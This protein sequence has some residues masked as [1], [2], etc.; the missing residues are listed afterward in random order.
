MTEPVAESKQPGGAVAGS[1]KRSVVVVLGMHRS[2]TSVLTRVVSLMGAALPD[3]L[4]PAAVDNPTGFWESRDVAVLDENLLRRAGLSWDG[5]L[6]LPEG[7]FQ[8]DALTQSQD[9][10]ADIMVD[11]LL[12]GPTAVI[13]DPRICRL[14]PLWR[15]AAEQAGLTL[16]CLLIFRNPLEVAS[17]LNARNGFTLAKSLLLWLRHN[18]EAERNTRGLSRMFINFTDLVNE[19]IGTIRRIQEFSGL[20]YDNDTLTEIYKFVN[21]ELRHADLESATVRSDPKVP[22]WVAT[23]YESLMCLIGDASHDAAKGAL[24]NILSEVEQSDRMFGPALRKKDEELE[25]ANRAI[26]DAQSRLDE[27]KIDL[28]AIGTKLSEVMTDRTRLERALE[29]IKTRQRENEKEKQRYQRQ[30]VASERAV[31]ELDR[32][33][34]ALQRS[35]EDLK[36]SFSWRLTKPARVLATMVRKTGKEHAQ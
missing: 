32:E 9:H 1:G 25:S 21:K 17:S 30:L 16:K 10:I 3:N 28:A 6:P 23:T 36:Q 31:V 5:I 22:R 4:I 26:W 13:K 33:I 11:T 20:Q 2:G 14:V 8:S 7:F 15:G 18:I 27:C 29:E 34:T 12:S 24:D 35:C 19:P